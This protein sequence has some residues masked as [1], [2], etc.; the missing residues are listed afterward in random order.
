[1]IKIIHIFAAT[2]SIS[3]FIL[4]GYLIFTASPYAKKR[5]LKVAP[6][7]ND[8]LLLVT[9]II[10]AIQL[11]YYPFTHDWL[12]A[13]VIALLLYI[14]LGMV[15]LHA[16]KTRGI[17]VGAWLLA[18]ATFGYIVTTALYKNPAWLLT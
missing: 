16:G 18:I 6:H 2:I 10:L 11:E 9:A 14:G 7:I 17:Q 3:L 13:K 4:R 1:M 8:T 15:A 5:V 12:T